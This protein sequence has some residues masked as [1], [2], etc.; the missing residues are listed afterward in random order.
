MKLTEKKAIKL[1]KELWEEVKAS[2]L[3]KENFLRTEAGLK[4]LGKYQN[5]CPL[6]EYGEQFGD[7]CLSCPLETKYDQDCYELGFS[8]VSLPSD[9]WMEAVRGL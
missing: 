8:E 2:G 5:D 6:C 3:S 9:S 1:C 7:A 4:W